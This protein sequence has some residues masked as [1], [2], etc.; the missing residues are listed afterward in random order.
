ML[1]AGISRKRGIAVR[2]AACCSAPIKPT[3]RPDFA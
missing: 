1:F 3:A 2:T